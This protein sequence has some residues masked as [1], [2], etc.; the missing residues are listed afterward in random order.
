MNADALDQLCLRLGVDLAY[1]D[2]WGRRTVVPDDSKRALLAAMG[3][4]IEAGQEDADARAHIAQ[5]DADAS[6]QVLPPIVVVEEGPAPLTLS[7]RLPAHLVGKALPWRI[8]LEQGGERRG[9]AVGRPASVTQPAPAE[10][11]PVATALELM[12]A[13]P[14]GYHRL[15]LYEPGHPPR[16]LAETGLCICPPTCF[17]AETQCGEHRVWGP[18]VQLYALRS[19]RDWGMG[20]FGDLRRLVDLAADAGAHFV[21]VNPLHALF[22]HDPERASPYSPSSREWLNVLYLDIEAM[23]DF[24]ECAGARELVASEP[25][26]ARLDG[27]RRQPLIDY[28]GVAALKFEVLELLYRNFRA[29]HLE[30]GTQRAGLF[31]DF[32]R[33]GGRSLRLHVLF[34]ALQSHFHRQDRALWGWTVWP[35]PYRD[36]DGLEVEAF[37]RA[38]EERIEFFAYL[39]WQADAQ[40]RTVAQRARARGMRI[41]LYRDLAV[42]VNEG[43]SETWA[44]PALHAL[45]AHAGAPPD[46][47]NSAGQ[48]WGFPPV[49]PRRLAAAAYAP[50]LA[51]VRANMR[52]AGALRIDHVMSLM[53]LFWLPVGR[54]AGLASTIGA[55][56]GYPMDEL[57]RLLC[58]ESQRQCCVVIGEDLGI[59][60]AEVRA[61]MARHGV[62]SYRPLYFERTEDGFRSPPAWERNALAVVGTHDLATLR[63]FWSGADLSLRVRLGLDADDD[64]RR[65]QAARRD[66]DRDALAGALRREGLLAGGPDALAAGAYERDSADPFLAAAVYRYIARTPARMVAVQFEDVLGQ[67]EAVNVPG[68]SEERHP[69]WRRR[70]DAELAD[71]AIDARWNAIVAAMNAERPCPPLPISAGP[72]DFHPECALIPRATYRLQFH[73]DFGFVAATAML[74]YLADLGISH[75]YAAPFLKARPGSRHGYDIVDHQAVNPEVGSEADFERYCARLA[76]L[77][78]GQVLDVVPNHVGV[79]GADNE[80]WLDVLEN[81]PASAHADHFDIDWEPPFAELR[82]KVLLPVL[83]DQYGL[84]LEAGELALDFCAETGE[85]SV[86]YFEHRFPID[87]SDYPMILAAGE[88]QGAEVAADVELETLLAALSHLPARDVADP[89]LQAER[90]HNKQTFKQHLADLYARKPALRERVAASLSAFN[91]T[92]G[93]PASFDAL[94]RLLGRQAYRLA[95]WRVAADDINYR[96]FF[97]VNDLAALRME[98]EPVFE[99]THA[100]IL[101]WL[102]EGRVSGLR[103]DHPDG[104]ADPAAYFERLQAR[105]AQTMA[106]AAQQHGEQAAAVPATPPA[107]LYLVVEKI[108]GEYE[109]LPA[110]WRVHGGTGYRFAN[111]CNNVFVDAAQE[112]RLSRIY[113][114]FTGEA[115]NFSEVL[116]ESKHLI[117]TH[118]LTGELGSL[119]YLAHDIAQRDRRTRDFTRSRL[120]GALAEIV[121]SFPI[122]RSYIGPGG[123]SDSDRRYVER[124][125]DDAAARALAGDASVL[126]FVGDVLLSA[127]NEPVAAT[128]KLK[129]QFVRRFQQFTAPV[130]AKSMEDTAFYRYNRLVSLNDVGGDPRTFGIAVEDFHAAN[131]RIA[132]SHPFGM[133]ASST[134]DSKRSEDVR[135]RIDVLSEM[136]GAWR[137][138]LRRWRQLNA[139]HKTRAGDE[140]APSGNDEYLLYQTLLGVWPMQQPDEEGLAELAGRVDAY[141]LKAARE[142]KQHTSWMNPEPDYERALSGFVRRLFAPGAEREAFLADFLPFQATVARFGAWNSLNMLLLKLTAPGVPDIYQGCETWNFRLVDPDNRRAVD[143]DAAREQLHTLRQAFPAGASRS[144]VGDLLAAIG[145][146]R[147]KLYLLWRVLSLRAVR[148]DE[149]RNGRYVP[150]DVDGPAARHVVAFARVLERRAVLVIASRLLFGLCGGDPERV[151]ERDLWARTVVTLPWWCG[152]V[153]WREILSGEKVQPRRLGSRH[154]VELDGLFATLPLALLI[155]DDGASPVDG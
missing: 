100:Q 101:R 68:T 141:M 134:H 93:E 69:N 113:R 38:N 118:S 71:I 62:L 116:L 108:F 11:V 102:G 147:I 79:L 33:E 94:D 119:A 150:L 148:E 111:L 121:A 72:A 13:L 129:L 126:R 4:A 103:I 146:G 2:A 124:A 132:G 125:V 80:W 115:R 83:G 25:F 42:G 54:G 122:Y 40:L 61:N 152:G 140:A 47:L 92:A 91:G 97:D 127:P 120:R 87:P 65:R 21:G 135:A 84:V 75:V 139:R 73:R 12:V 18:S 96:R 154:C 30:R 26:T 14:A 88:A 3:Y 136:P 22:P 131:E 74:P 76:E 85:F 149:F 133:L 104:L 90:R 145:D 7:P 105:Y 153:S 27:L 39:Q 78:L 110:E 28:S 50:F 138:A 142:A 52:Y 86:R 46:E 43:G 151:L 99:A 51:V 5:I 137:L 37:A 24:G 17:T 48:D 66:A 130:M 112:S 67:L 19:A 95:S 143:F 1:E 155:A 9:L 55:Y 123:V 70:L 29:L 56:V 58:L 16:L 31:R 59:V 23:R 35:A 45:D 60:P 106:S 144:G 36:A 89:S 41:G 114:A 64:L 109:P 107:P 128:R 49:I 6:G 15:A 57:F 53:R 82:G 98:H 34:E 63:G 8:R 117:M 20:D 77:G 81:G 32:Q 44:Q 10:S